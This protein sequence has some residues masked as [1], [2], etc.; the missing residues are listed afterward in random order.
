VR[1]RMHQPDTQFR[2]C[3]Q[4]P[5]IHERRA[6]VDIHAGG[7]PAG[8]QGGLQGDTEADGVLGE[9]EP[10]ATDQSGMVVEEREQ[11]GLAAADL[12]AVQGVP[13]PA[14]IRV[15]GFE[16]PEHRRG[17]PGGRTDQLAPVKV[18]QQ[19]RFRRRPARAGPQD[20]LHLRGGAGRVLPF[21]RCGQ[22]QRRGVG[23][24]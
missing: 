4:Q 12:R 21:Q 20:P 22:L 2:A 9:S 11:V 16:P 13:G 15:L 8:G 17:V 1:G 19:C 6:V 14:V 7:N 24:R 18:A 3:P 23:A 10:V 5:G